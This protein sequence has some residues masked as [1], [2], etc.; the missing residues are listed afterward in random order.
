MPVNLRGAFDEVSERVMEERRE[1]CDGDEDD[2]CFCC[3]IAQM[4]L[5]R[6]LS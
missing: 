1:R 5:A 2:A 6:L 4:L 3:A